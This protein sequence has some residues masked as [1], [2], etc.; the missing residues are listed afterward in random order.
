MAGWLPAGG[1]HDDD[2]DE[3][4]DDSDG[5]YDDDYVATLCL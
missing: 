1:D 4:G 2:G 5:V 3:D